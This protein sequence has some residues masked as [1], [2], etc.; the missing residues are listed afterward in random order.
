MEFHGLNAP[1]VQSSGDYLSKKPLKLQ[2]NSASV[3]VVIDEVFG[4]KFFLRQ[5]AQH[6]SKILRQPPLQMF[7]HL[8]ITA[9]LHRK[10]WLGFLANLCP[11]LRSDSHRA[12]RHH[13]S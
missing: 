13:L 1:T 3:S 4:A 12:L 11:T 9:K 7:E 6:H 8:R 5:V 2:R 10:I